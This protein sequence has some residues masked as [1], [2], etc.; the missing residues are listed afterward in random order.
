MARL[1]K[2]KIPTNTKMK[3][4]IPTGLNVSKKILLKKAQTVKASEVVVIVE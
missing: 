1:I 4:R 3:T 2:K